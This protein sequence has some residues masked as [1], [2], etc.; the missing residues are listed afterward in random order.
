MMDLPSC[1]LNLMTHQ[2]L[3]MENQ[4]SPS[5]LLFHPQIHL[6]TLTGW[7]WNYVAK[8]RKLLH[9]SQYWCLVQNQTEFGRKNK[10][11][12]VDN[13]VIK[14][15]KSQNIF[16]N[17][18]VVSTMYIMS[19]ESLFL[20]KECNALSTLAN[21]AMIKQYYTSLSKTSTSIFAC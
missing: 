3:L 12:A 15:I 8:M 21:W 2:V 4:S 10:K 18:A 17:T 5:S 14:V 9:S 20:W 16:A 11:N 13:P 7:A 6:R 1:V 19:G